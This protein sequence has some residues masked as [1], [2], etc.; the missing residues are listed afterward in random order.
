ML[1][2]RKD[3]DS[4]QRSDENQD[5]CEPLLSE[6]HVPSSCVLPVLGSPGLADIEARRDGEDEREY[7]SPLA[8]A[9]STSCTMLAGVRSTPTCRIEAQTPWASKTRTSAE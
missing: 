1:R 6:F 5:R 4:R 2:S 8:S 7:W 9:V 3:A